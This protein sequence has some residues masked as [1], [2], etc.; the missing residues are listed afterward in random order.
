LTAEASAALHGAAAL[1]CLLWAAIALLAG[2]RPLSL[3]PAAACLA[4]AAWAAAV[5]LAPDRP[6]SGLPGAFEV[7]SRGAWAGLLVALMARTGAGRVRPFALAA[8]GLALAALGLDLLGPAG[9]FA[10]P[11]LGSPSLLARL[12]L[13]LLVLVAAENLLR[14]TDEAAGWHVNLPCIV[15]GGLAAL[16]VVLYADAALSER[17]S[18]SLL[19]ARAGIAALALALLALA[20]FRDRRWK[21]RPAVSREAAF[22]GAT[23]LV[24]GAFLLG[25]GGVGEALRRSGT[26]WSNAAQVGLLA[27]AGMALAVALGSRSARSRLRRLVADHFF[28]ARFDYRAE[29]LRCVAT[30]SAA[31]GA[32]PPERRAVRAVADA[33]DSPGGVLLL[34]GEA[35]GLAWAGSWNMPAAAP[36]AAEVEALLGRIGEA[37][38]LHL[39]GGAAPPGLAAAYG[40]LWLAVPLPHRGGPLGLVL[41]APPRA[42]FPLDDEALALLA[43]LAREVALFLAER[44]AATR[45][46]DQRQLAGY[47]QRFA[48][49]AH[50]VKTVSAQLRLMLDNAGPNIADPAFQQDLLTTLRASVGRIDALIARLRHDGE[51]P[52][53]ARRPGPAL[54]DRLR[55]L[56]LTI[57]HPVEV[58]VEEGGQALPSPAMPAE[59]FD[60]A[61][62]HLLNNAAE[63]SPPGAPVRLAAR[64]DG[65]QGLVVEIEDRGPGMSAEFVRD[66][67]FRPLATTKPGGSG[68]GAW[69]ARELLAQAGGTLLVDSAPGRGTRLHLRLP[70]APLAGPLAGPFAPSLTSPVA[71]PVA[72]PVASPVAFPGASPVASPLGAALA[73]GR[74]LADT[75]GG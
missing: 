18:S 37:P 51:T 27:G 11:S 74:P 36:P 4:T 52:G 19:D 72:P 75:G 34:R 28:A 32:A 55:R 48:F 29:W 43:T 7:L 17:F 65:V 66:Q 23:L 68:I 31:E 13:A 59:N 61:V 50:D 49:V 42:P 5:A 33:V 39:A 20:A 1:L 41:L 64:R 35:G 2:R 21:R 54:A 46:A 73:E 63:A 24:S 6:L 30:L 53:E 62:T 3:I 69:Q 56:A 26:E 22:H 57:G 16:D 10:L 67:L 60:A 44:E 15:L 40:P 58:E 71:S 38:A 9:E 45:L 47:A 25:V 14:N 12:A 8:G 70:A